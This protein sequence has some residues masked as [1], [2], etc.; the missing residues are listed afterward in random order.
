MV[1]TSTTTHI[2]DNFGIRH[3]W[4]NTSTEETG[5]GKMASSYC[6][7]C[8]RCVHRSELFLPIQAK[9]EARKNRK[10]EKK[11]PH[12]YTALFN[13][14]CSNSHLN[15]FLFFFN[16]CLID[17]DWP[18]N[19]PNTDSPA[20]QAKQTQSNTPQRNQKDFLSYLS[21]VWDVSKAGT[22]TTFKKG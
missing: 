14:P 16:L 3:T 5:S 9:K 15:P 20:L 4:P 10:I 19:G 2:R 1:N 13:R 8:R 17:L 11:N 12:H 22:S 7:Q 18:L 21:H 6:G